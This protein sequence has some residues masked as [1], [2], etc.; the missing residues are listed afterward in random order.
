MKL[1]LLICL[2]HVG[3]AAV[4]SGQDPIFIGA[5]AS[6][7]EV[8]EGSGTILLQDINRD[9]RQD[10]VTRH[11]LTKRIEVLRGDG[12]GGFSAFGPTSDGQIKPDVVSV[13][14]GTYLSTSGGTVGTSSGT[15]FSGPN[16]AGLAT[17]LWQLFPEFNSYKIIETLR[18]SADGRP[19]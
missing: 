14:Q 12:K 4:L 8:G 7:I 1:T 17:C 16:M 9:G 19:G 6:P 18:K 15:S 10:L 13:G 11:L 3:S 5:P 2:M